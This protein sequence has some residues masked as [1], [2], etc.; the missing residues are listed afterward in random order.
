MK[1]PATIWNLKIGLYI[2]D[3]NGLLYADT[4]AFPNDLGTINALSEFDFE[5]FPTDN[6][7]CNYE[8]F[9]RRR[10]EDPSERSLAITRLALRDALRYK[11][12]PIAF[13]SD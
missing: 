10:E 1:A 3:P 11:L 9:V 4:D 5:T 8:R 12:S 2:R 6:E 13:M 7:I